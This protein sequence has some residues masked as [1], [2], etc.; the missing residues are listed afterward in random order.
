MWRDVI[1]AF[2]RIRGGDL[3]VGIL[4]IP[5]QFS[6]PIFP[7]NFPRTRRVIQPMFPTKIAGTL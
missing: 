2:S 7:P 4:P 1:D 5:T 6:H 3:W